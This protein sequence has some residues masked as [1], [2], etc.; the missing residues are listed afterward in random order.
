MVGQR[1]GRVDP[2]ALLALGAQKERSSVSA[3]TSAVEK[4]SLLRLFTLSVASIIGLS[5]F[6]GIVVRANDD[7]GALAFIR[8]QPVAQ[9][10]TSIFARRAPQQTAPVY[11][12]PQAFFP[13]AAAPAPRRDIIIASYAPFGGYFPTEAAEPRQ[14]RRKA[15]GARSAPVKLSLA[16]PERL[17]WLSGGGNVA[18]CVRT[19]DGFYFP[20][21]TATGSDKTDE[22]ACNQL[23]PTSETR[24]FV[25][26]GTAD[27]DDAIA[28]DSGKKYA[29][30]ANAFSY[31][32]GI[33]KSC[34]CSGS[35]F[36]LA[37]GLPVSRDTS[38]R[39]GDIIMTKTGMKIFSGG[40]VPYREG[41]FTAISSSGLIDKKTREHLRQLEIAS[42]PGRSGV[43]ARQET[44]RSKA[45]EL[46]ELK[47]ATALAQRGV[48][49]ESVASVR[50]VGPN[51]VNAS[52]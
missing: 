6:G 46:K 31:R 37:S 44:R 4:S 36:G 26:Q 18:Y 14:P 29:S 17:R 10:R 43:E 45:D 27:I 5:A 15:A 1:S 25:S 32:K 34:S 30:F 7:N 33:D 20:L 22:A 28:R 23:C 39:A 48:P 8:Q 11:Y 24:V 13:R 19:C 12:A 38:L 40:S 50:Y 47:A 49:L 16:A 3:G 51:R 9:G 42:L 35:G 52:P 2:R 41:H 21:S